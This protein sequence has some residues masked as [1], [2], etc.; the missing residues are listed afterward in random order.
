MKDD[1]ETFDFIFGMDEENISDLKRMAPGNCR[2]K[3]G[4]LGEFDP[5]GERIIRDPYYV[6]L[7]L[8]TTRNIIV[9]LI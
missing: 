4:L 1:F 5:Q 2:A 9:G 7:Y 6:S 8:S 3:I